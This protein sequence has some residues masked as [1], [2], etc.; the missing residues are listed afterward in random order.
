[1][2]Y[3]G[4]SNLLRKLSK[5]AN[6]QAANCGNSDFELARWIEEEHLWQMKLRNVDADDPENATYTVKHHVLV[7]ACG[8]LS[9]PQIPEGINLD[10]YQGTQFHS[11]KWRHDVT[12]GIKKSRF[13]YKHL[14]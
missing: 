10:V 6:L 3:T 12:L 2:V 1:M 9:Q 4:I 13:L 11:Q 5:V 7:M 14:D 8:P